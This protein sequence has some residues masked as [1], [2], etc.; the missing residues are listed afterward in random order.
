ML[1]GW[2]GLRIR[3]RG[4]R[5][6]RIG[7]RFLGLCVLDLCRLLCRVCVWLGLLGRR[8]G[9]RARIELLLGLVLGG[10]CCLLLWRL[11]WGAFLGGFWWFR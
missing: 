5:I 3:R 1:V 11:A 7:R 2:L 6:A 4:A 8:L 9:R 10:E